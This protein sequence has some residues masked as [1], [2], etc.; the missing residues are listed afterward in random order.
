[1][2]KGVTK[3]QQ[4]LWY[5]IS[6]QLY[7]IDEGGEQL[8]NVEVECVFGLWLSSGLKMRESN[9]VIL[10]TTSIIGAF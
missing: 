1:M 10:N 3:L 7:S 4:H 6:E 9:K 2:S 5:K 8:R